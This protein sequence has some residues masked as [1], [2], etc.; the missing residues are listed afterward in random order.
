MIYSIPLEDIEQ[1]FLKDKGITVDLN[2]D[3][4]TVQIEL[5]SL[6]PVRRVPAGRVWAFNGEDAIMS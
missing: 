5:R 2:D 3:V 6:Q 4:F 1:V